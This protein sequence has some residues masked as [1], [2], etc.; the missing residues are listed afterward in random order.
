[1]SDQQPKRHYGYK[2]D[3]VKTGNMKSCRATVTSTIPSVDLRSKCPP[4]YDQGQLGSCV[5]NGVAFCH[6][7]DQ[8]KQGLKNTFAPSRLFVYYN[9]RALDGTINEDAGAQIHDGIQTIKQYGVCAESL[10]P[11]D[12]SKFAVKP[13]ASSYVAAEK[14]Q[15]IKY[16]QINQAAADIEQCLIEGYPVVFGMMVYDDFEGPVVAKTG[17]VPM[18]KGNTVGGHCMVIVGYHR[19]KQLFTV[20]NSWG[21]NWGDGGY[22]YVPYGYM[23]DRTQAQDFW[24]IESVETG[25][26][27]APIPT[28]TPAPVPTPT[29]ALVPITLIPGKPLIGMMVPYPDSV[30]GPFFIQV[31]KQ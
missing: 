18:P 29:P 27:V 7:F 10:W 8:I 25:I 22:C 30:K 5:G 16:Q 6:Q 31:Y 11:Y 21:M 3:A 24:I 15:S 9:A 26:D 1:M 17:M 23:L 12:P 19:A 13:A 2:K 14:S 28:P 4:V 20:R